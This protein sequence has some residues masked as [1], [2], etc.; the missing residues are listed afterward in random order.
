MLINLYLII[1]E[2]ASLHVP[3]IVSMIEVPRLEE[4]LLWMPEANFMTIV[5]WVR[6]IYAIN[7][8]LLNTKKKIRKKKPRS[9]WVCKQV[10]TEAERELVNISAEMGMGN[11][12]CKYHAHMCYC[13]DHWHLLFIANLTSTH[14]I[15]AVYVLTINFINVISSGH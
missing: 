8:W 15:F 4:L 7:H 13:F 10:Q 11:F 1:L 6:K 5:N 12:L 14:L 3:A 9:R 2:V